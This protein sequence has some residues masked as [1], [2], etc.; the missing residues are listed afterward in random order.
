MLSLII[1]SS[2]TKIRDFAFDSCTGLKSVTV[3][4]SDPE[5]I[6][7]G[8]EI[9][10]NVNTSDCTLF[11]PAGSLS[12]YK[13][14]DQWKEFGRILEIVTDLTIDRT[15]LELSEGETETLVA[16]P[17][18]ENLED[19]TVLWTSSDEEVATVNANGVVS[20][21]KIGRTVITAT[22][23]N[24]SATCE[25]IVRALDSIE[26]V[27]GDKRNVTYYTLD[28]VRIDEDKIVSGIY[29]KVDG[30]KVSRIH[31]R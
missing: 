12:L 16:T 2:I 10:Y 20:A 28:G 22:C 13:V 31:I 4:N 5:T 23:S 6:F 8:F 30:G 3:E 17:L 25:V 19:K 29:I 26:N 21:V 14:A 24:K 18:P 15:E 1:P 11:V 7:I 27:I 9:F